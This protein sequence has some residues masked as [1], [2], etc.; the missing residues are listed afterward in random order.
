[1]RLQE[2]AEQFAQRAAMLHDGMAAALAEVRNDVAGQTIELSLEV[3]RQVI[4]T[5]LSTT[6]QSIEPVV[7]EAIASLIDEQTG[8]TLQLSPDDAD[9]LG[10]ILEPLLHARGARIVPDPAIQTGGCRIISSGAEIDATLRTRW[11]RVLAA[12][13]IPEAERGDVDPSDHGSQP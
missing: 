12:I 3:A 2:I 7:R 1:M 9:L 5:Q 6:P 13:G 4:R 8:F 11:L 10:P